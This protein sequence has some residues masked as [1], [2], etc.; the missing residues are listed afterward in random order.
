LP[1]RSLSGSNPAELGPYFTV[2]FE[3]PLTW[4][5]M[6]PYLYSPRT[7]WL[8][9]TPG[10]WVSS[11]SPLTTRYGG[12]ILTRLHT[13][14]AVL[15][16][17]KILSIGEGTL[18]TCYSFRYRSDGEPRW[19]NRYSDWLRAGLDGRGVGFRCPVG[20]RIFSF[21][22]L[23][24][25]HYCS[26][27]LLSPVVKRQERKVNHSPPTSTQVNKTWIHTSIPQKSSWHNWVQGQ[28]FYRSEGPHC[29][30]GQI[31]G[32][33]IISK[34]LIILKQNSYS[35]Y[36]GCSEHDEIVNFNCK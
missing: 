34:Q 4:R 28:L 22:Y 16:Q 31:I 33:D 25:R 20:S 24:E 23:P 17:I 14:D 32:H 1:E 11:P 9:Y 7:G 27:S 8:S 10:H 5:S 19:R 18:P 6:S 30:Y 2:S 15:V 21:P 35:Y 13:G 29:T 12:G 36:V 3:T 26:P